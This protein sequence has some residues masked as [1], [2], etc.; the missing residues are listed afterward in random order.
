MEIYPQA[1]LVASNVMWRLM[2]LRVTVAH[3]LLSSRTLILSYV[4]AM[5]LWIPEIIAL[6]IKFHWIMLIA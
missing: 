4:E 6:E 3:L 5:F 1:E 2:S